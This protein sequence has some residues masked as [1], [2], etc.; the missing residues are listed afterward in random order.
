[1]KN[2][3]DGTI[4]KN[5]DGSITQY[6]TAFDI[7]FKFD[8][9]LKDRYI[10]VHGEVQDLKGMDRA[11]QVRYKLPVNATGWLWGDYIRKSREIESGIQYKNVY[12]IGETR[13]QNAYPFASISNGEQ[14]LSLAVPMNV[15]RIYRIGYDTD[16][17]YFI[18][19]DF[20]L[21]NCTD[22]IGPGYANFTFIIYKNR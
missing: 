8:Y 14:G 9:I 21:V 17:G 5:A 20:G 7:V 4:E 15:P 19:Y 11:I 10:E 2:P 3:L 12:K 13:T 6:V 16:V 18:E 1:M 22:K